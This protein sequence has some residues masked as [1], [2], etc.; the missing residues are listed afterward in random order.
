MSKDSPTVYILHGDDE[1]DIQ[2]LI[3]HKLKPLMGESANAEMNITTLDGKE[4]S[5]RELE[6][7]TH[8]M[9]F[10][11]E[12]RMVILSHPLSLGEKRADREDFLTLLEKIP[13]STACILK[14]NT[15]LD[16]SHWLIRWSQAHPDL[17]WCKS[18]PLPKGQNMTRW[19]QDRAQSQG[20]EFSSDA[21][22][23]L[24]IYVN[25]DPRLASQEIEKL[26]TY[27]NFDR[28]VTE[29]DVRKLTADVRQGDVFEMVDAISRGDGETA[30][31]MLRR[32]LQEKPALPLFGMIVRQFRLLILVSEILDQDP[33]RDRFR[34][35]EEL[36]VHPYP[37]QKIIPQTKRFSL[38][39]LE[40]IYR[41][42][43]DVD[44]AMKR[45]QLDQELA[46]DLLIAAL[47]Q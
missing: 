44:A 32:Q 25:E 47:T 37:I 12:R 15:L 1:F 16:E 6:S 3:N 35:A 8:A 22:R 41:Q 33:K 11:T 17:T 40:K 23:L 26:L 18:F 29:E 30:M 13:K 36:D 5:L 20:G 46:L 45:G 24:A 4:I 39:Q 31:R 7:E 43:S 42:L 9:P 38:P 27:A 10:L 2:E 34:I 19:I 21:A 14:T 28:K